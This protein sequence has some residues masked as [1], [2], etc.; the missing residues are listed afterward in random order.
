MWLYLKQYNF[1]GLFVL[2]DICKDVSGSPSPIFSFMG[3]YD[4]NWRYIF[5][6]LNSIN[7][8]NTSISKNG[9]FILLFT[10]GAGVFVSSDRQFLLEGS[11]KFINFVDNL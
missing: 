4:H 10:V 11:F 1:C 7:E 6:N 2:F 3:L 8:V 9:L 5:K